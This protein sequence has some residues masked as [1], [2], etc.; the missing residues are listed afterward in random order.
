MPKGPYTFNEKNI[1]VEA[2]KQ[3]K[4]WYNKYGRLHEIEKM[5]KNHARNA[6]TKLFIQYGAKVML[7][8]LYRA[9]QKQGQGR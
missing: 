2:L 9:L 8:P 3:G 1:P 5:N 4:F 7:T 6:L